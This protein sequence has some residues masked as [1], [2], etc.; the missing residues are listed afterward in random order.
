MFWL[1]IICEKFEKKRVDIHSLLPCLLVPRTFP[2][3]AA[4]PHEIPSGNDFF[5]RSSTGQ[6]YIFHAFYVGESQAHHLTVPVV[7][8]V[9]HRINPDQG[10]VIPN[11]RAHFLS[12]SVQTAVFVAVQ[13]AGSGV[14]WLTHELLGKP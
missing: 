4:S 14:A 2:S 11:F 3:S 12:V 10:L 7:V 5:L 9:L 8:R 1:S 6:R 13:V